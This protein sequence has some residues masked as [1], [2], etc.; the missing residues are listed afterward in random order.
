MRNPCIYMAVKRVAVTLL[1]ASIGIALGN[2][3]KEKP[4]DFLIILDPGHGG[5]D[6][7]CVRN[8]ILEK[9]INL[10]IALSVRTKLTELGYQVFLTRDSDME[11]TLE[12]RVKTANESGADL[13]IS[14]HQNSSEISQAKGI[15]LYYSAQYEGEESKRLSELI[16]QYTIEGTGA[17]RR[18]IFEWEDLYVIRE[19]TMPSCLVE[20]GFLSNTSERRKLIS[21]T[22]QDQIS[23]GIVSGIE[24]YLFP[25]SRESYSDNSSQ[26][27]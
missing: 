3:P 16:Q 18:E 11:L 14:I 19:C 12:E 7:G 20:T 9:D 6:D 17:A 22:Y 8:G 4:E 5:K 27:S 23:D 13:F 2:I 10:Q 21:P 1:S 25:D 26:S 15:E 24:Q